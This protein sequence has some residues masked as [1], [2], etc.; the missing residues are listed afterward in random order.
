MTAIRRLRVLPVDGGQS[1]VVI[2]DEL[3]GI[4]SS[5]VEVCGVGNPGH[6]IWVGLVKKGANFLRPLDRPPDMRVWSDRHT[7]LQRSLAEFCHG[8]RDR[9]DI[10]RGCSVL[11]AA[12]HVD[13]EVRAA[14]DLQEIAAEIALQALSKRPKDLADVF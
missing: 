9:F 14:E 1:V 11:R 4:A 5:E 12:A 13:L 3:N 2:V 10:I 6:D 7:H 8:F